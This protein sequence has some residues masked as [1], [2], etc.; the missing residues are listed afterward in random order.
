[1]M[2][3][4]RGLL[5]VSPVCSCGV[6]TSIVLIFSILQ[7]INGAPLSSSP[8]LRSADTN[9]AATLKNGIQ[10]TS[11]AGSV[12]DPDILEL[13]S[14]QELAAMDPELSSIN[15]FMVDLG[16]TFYLEQSRDITMFMP[17]DKAFRNAGIDLS[18]LP[19]SAK[20]RLF[21]YHVV[22]QVVIKL[23]D[24]AEG[25]EVEYSSWEGSPLTLTSAGA[26]RRGKYKL[27][28]KVN[29]VGNPPGIE[30]FNGISYKVDKVLIPP[31]LDKTSMVIEDHQSSGITRGSTTAAADGTHPRGSSAV[32]AEPTTDGRGRFVGR[33]DSTTSV[34]TGSQAPQFVQDI[35]SAHSRWN[36]TPDQ[37]RERAGTP[38]GSVDADGTTEEVG[39][40]RTD[41]QEIKNTVVSEREN[42]GLIPD[43]IEDVTSFDE[44]V[45]GS[46]SAIQALGI[47]GGEE[48]ISPDS[49]RLVG[50][51]V[52]VGFGWVGNLPG[53]TNSSPGHVSPASSSA[54]EGVGITAYLSEEESVATGVEVSQDSG[55][56]G[57]RRERNRGR[58]YRARM[59]RNGVSEDISTRGDRSTARFITPVSS[60]GPHPTESFVAPF[61]SH[62]LSSDP[63]MPLLLSMG[64]SGSSSEFDAGQYDVLVSTDGSTAHGYTQHHAL[65]EGTPFSAIEAFDPHVLPSE[66]HGQAPGLLPISNYSIQALGMSEIKEDG[67]VEEGDAIVKALHLDD[68]FVMDPSAGHHFFPPSASSVSNMA[69]TYE[70]NPLS[71]G[72]PLGYEELPYVA[73]DDYYT[74]LT[75]RDWHMDAVWEEHAEMMGEVAGAPEV[76]QYESVDVMSLIKQQ[77]ELSRVSEL[78]GRFSSGG[79]SRMVRKIKMTVFAPVNEAIQVPLGDS[80][81]EQIVDEMKLKGISEQ[82]ANNHIT[83][84]RQLLPE[85]LLV[86]ETVVVPAKGHRTKIHI[87][88]DSRG[89]IFVNDSARVLRILR[90]SNGVLY[91]IDQVLTPKYN[92]GPKLTELLASDPHLSITN[93]LVGDGGGGLTAFAGV[94]PVTVFLVDD[95]GF[96]G[97]DGLPLPQCVMKALSEPENKRQ[98]QKLTA[99]MVLED[100]VSV[101]DMVDGGMLHPLH[102]PPVTVTRENKQWE[103]QDGGS[104][105]V[106]GRK[107][108]K[109][110]IPIHNGLAHIIDGQLPLPEVDMHRLS[111]WTCL[112][113]HLRSTNRQVRMVLERVDEFKS[114]PVLGVPPGP[115]PAWVGE[116]LQRYFPPHTSYRQHQHS[117]RSRRA[118]W[119]N[120]GGGVGAWEYVETSE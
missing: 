71:G 7:P 120:R 25:E 101:N 50:S 13:A 88:K 95:S 94:G 41:R 69:S 40:I 60:N 43:N 92:D 78:M 31:G 116:G 90:G 106:E 107:I 20:W 51:E 104:V 27:N 77:P 23:E 97:H 93:R 87:R 84:G 68:S 38:P 57:N 86:G 21:Q 96:V 8:L 36:D 10:Q 45:D 62:P 109:A 108:L 58:R 98:M 103:H 99:H 55:F 64:P 1:M 110:N 89:N 15:K 48:V 4:F 19:W 61:P 102:G 117:G 118:P 17:T 82:V 49:V 9:S 30:N 16:A 3:C 53:W 100:L 33:L 6:L 12:K 32:R 2:A 66:Y 65:H 18:L 81:L 44:S 79:S 73:T 47:E 114:L 52:P 67:F 56:F 5:K 75:G 26:V 113:E 24:I 112:D 59:Q 115:R 22:P 83:I 91:E 54:G 34:V 111:Y 14:V 70:Y 74:P 37:R 39:L 63:A 72:V 85:R 119:F 11:G 29:I 46:P 76:V 42:V 35:N 105:Y 28:G 80:G